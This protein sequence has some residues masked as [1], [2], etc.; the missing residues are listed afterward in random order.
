[1]ND[2]IDFYFWCLGQMWACIVAH[3]LLGAF[4][5]VLIIGW[6]VSLINSTMKK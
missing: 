4:I 3:W 1:M 5:L 6:V 2:V